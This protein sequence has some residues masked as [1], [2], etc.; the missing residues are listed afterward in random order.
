M[1]TASLAD[2][3]DLD[4]GEIAALALELGIA[5]LLID[6]Q[7]AR[8]VALQLGLRVS[9]LLG[10]LIEA[11]HR[12]LTPEV[13]PLLDRLVLGARFWISPNLR[14]QILLRAGEVSNS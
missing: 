13:R 9:G 4:P 7:L 5:D 10:V 12:G 2:H 14:S 3:P 8:T 11:K 1:I 6:E